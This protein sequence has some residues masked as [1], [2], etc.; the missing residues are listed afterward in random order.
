MR[1]TLQGNP[2]AIWKIDCKSKTEEREAGLMRQGSMQ[3]MRTWKQSPHAIDIY[4]G[5]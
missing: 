1:F 2:E 5:L 4:T 3:E